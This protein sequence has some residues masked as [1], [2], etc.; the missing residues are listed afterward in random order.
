MQAIF[1]KKSLGF[2]LCAL[3]ALS[4]AAWAQPRVSVHPLMAEQGPWG[5]RW[6]AL[7]MRE[8]AKQNIDMRPEVMV[9]EFLEARGGSCNNETSCLRDLGYATRASYVLVAS[10]FRTENTYAVHARI[11][12]VNGV[13]V[14]QVSLNVESVSKTSQE[15]NAMAVYGQLL[16][17]LM[18]ESLPL[19]P[20][21][22][23]LERPAVVVEEVTKTKESEVVP[24][25]GFQPEEKLLEERNRGMS[26]MRKGAYVMWGVAGATAV[27]GTAFALLANHNFNNYKKNYADIEN[28]R[29][30]G[31]NTDLAAT[32]ELQKKFSTQKTIS[33][34]AFSVAAAAAIAGTTLFFLS[35]EQSLNVGFAP[36]EGGVV[37]SIQGVFPYTGIGKTKPVKVL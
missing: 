25:R 27:T 34:I 35:P 2:L 23:S 31:A 28:P 16:E 1:H 21:G 33:I 8:V 4:A 11:V 32:L 6:N 10:M 26:P 9:K 13:E 19:H 24:D 37:F 29:V 3:W 7:F 17:E 22:V 12:G 20:P 18:L 15:A 30:A 14:K 36:T 5:E